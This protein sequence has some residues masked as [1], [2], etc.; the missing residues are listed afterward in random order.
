MVGTFVGIL[1]VGILV[2]RRVGKLVGVFVGR[3]DGTFVG[4]F[5]GRPDGKLVVGK[6]DGI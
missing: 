1:V 5:V 4:T 2:G 3:P 6:L